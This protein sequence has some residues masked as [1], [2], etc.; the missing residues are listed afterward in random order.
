MHPREI[1]EAGGRELTEA[2]R[3]TIRQAGLSYAEVE[4]RLGMGRDSLRQLLAGRV[5]LK[6]KHLL[7]V[8][9][10]VGIEPA[11]FFA[12]QFGPPATPRYP[13]PSASPLHPDFAARLQ[14]VEN[15]ALW[16][17]ARK[18]RDKGLLTDDEVESYVEEFERG[19]AGL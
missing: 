7:G 13:L 14:R 3:R 10:A 2:L 19:K 11:A 4:R 6:V 18:L 5:D 12:E 15:A 1:G 17:L 16:F 8:L 9:A